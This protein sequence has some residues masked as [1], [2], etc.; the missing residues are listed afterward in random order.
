MIKI[1][2]PLKREWIKEFVTSLEFEG[3]PYNFVKEK[4]MDLYF[5]LETDNLDQAVRFLKDN[6]KA[7]KYGGIINYS[8]SKI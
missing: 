5:E 1:S 3:K 6:I 4:K 2:S 8:I 7:S